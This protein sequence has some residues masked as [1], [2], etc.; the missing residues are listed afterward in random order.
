M[1]GAVR[2]GDGREDAVAPSLGNVPALIKY[3]DDGKSYQL[4][5]TAATLDGKKY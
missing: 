2:R 3:Q 4:K 1:F 5:L